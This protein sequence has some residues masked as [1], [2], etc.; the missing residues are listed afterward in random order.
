MFFVVVM[1]RCRGDHTVIVNRKSH[2]SLKPD[3]ELW[4]SV[5]WDPNNSPV[6]YDTEAKTSARDF[7]DTVTRYVASGTAVA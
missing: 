1:C 6:H 3:L 2:A 4:T 7:H 5:H